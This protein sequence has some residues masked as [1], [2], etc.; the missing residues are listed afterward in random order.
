MLSMLTQS[1]KNSYSTDSHAGSSSY[2]ML[3]KVDTTDLLC[4]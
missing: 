1:L 2:L 3:V 4:L